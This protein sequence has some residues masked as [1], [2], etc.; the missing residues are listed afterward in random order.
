[1]HHL[2]NRSFQTR[3]TLLVFA[4]LLSLP[5]ASLLSNTQVNAAS[6]F[7]ADGWGYFDGNQANGGSG[8][9]KC[10][11][12]SDTGNDC[13]VLHDGLPASVNSA[14]ELYNYVKNEYDHGDY[15]AQT[16]AAFLVKSMLG[17]G[18]ADRGRGYFPGRNVDGAMWA[19]WNAAINNSDLDMTWNDTSYTANYDTGM[20]AAT[21]VYRVNHTASGNYVVFKIGGNVVYAINRECANPDG[22]YGKIPDPNNWS[23]SRSSTVTSI[24]GTSSTSTAK[25]GS[26]VTWSHT[27]KNNG[28]DATDKNVVTHYQNRIDN[29]P[30]SAAWN[31]PGTEGSGGTVGVNFASGASTSYNSTYVI[32]AS[33]IGKKLCRATSTKPSSSTDGE[34]RESNGDCVT[35]PYDFSLVPTTNTLDGIIEPGALISDIYPSINNTGSSPSNGP[36]QWELDKIV[37]A[38]TGTITNASQTS[39]SAPCVVFANTCTTVGTGNQVFPP[40]N[41]PVTTLAGEVVPLNT[42]VGTRICFA[43]S[44]KPYK[45]G[46]TDWRLSAPTCVTVAKKPKVQ[47]LGGDLVVGRGTVSNP[48]ATSNVVTSTSF[49]SDPVNLYYGSWS[50]YAII[51]SGTVTGMASG[52][53]Y[54]GG[55]SDSNLCKLSVLTI[56]NVTTG[57]SCTPS[58]PSKIGKYNNTSIAPDAASRFPVETTTP[59]ITTSTK[60]I[61]SLTTGQTWTTPATLSNL[62]IT[63]STS[64]GAGK[65]VVINAPDTT[66]TISS[67]IYV[68]VSSSSAHTPTALTS[69]KDIPQVVIIAKNIIIA[70]NVKNVDAW[71]IA[72]GG[73]LV[74]NSAGVV[75]GRAEDGILNTC[76]IGGTDMDPT[77]LNATNCAVPLTINGPI[78][79]NHLLLRR[80]GGAAVGAGT[81]QGTPAETFNLRADAYIWASAYSPGNGRLPTVSNQELP[82]R[83]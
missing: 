23:I 58:V 35:V 11:H 79:A 53:M 73:S 65:W 52:A 74:K 12:D 66:I 45:D 62:S 44:V 46:S 75:V 19:Q 61:S 37:V 15:R 8:S 25:V 57:S 82:P 9:N 81:T 5:I 56:S 32:K 64:F 59:K 6:V 27:V 10:Y 80:T 51:P 13:F 31:D 42:P 2:K 14:G 39:P 76:A 41:T 54:A 20:D 60:D 24:S 3:I 16:G 28:P 55:S 83:F 38:P 70:D 34:W 77:H 72:S 67:D 43:L 78:M 17:I 1:M 36:S 40:G 7:F 22:S 26:T 68:G 47:V 63:S 21:D 48:E 33:D 4:F 29:T 30:A 18:E 71:L 50:E 49:A 69:I